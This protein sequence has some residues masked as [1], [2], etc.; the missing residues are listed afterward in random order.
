MRARL[1]LFALRPALALARGFRS[2]P[3]GT[4][5]DDAGAVRVVVTHDPGIGGYAI[6]LTLAE[7][8]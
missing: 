4:P 7:G 3:V 5:A 8:A 1:A 6:A 2:D